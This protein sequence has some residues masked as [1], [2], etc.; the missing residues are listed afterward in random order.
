MNNRTYQLSLTNAEIEA[1]LHH[2]DSLSLRT[3]REDNN[4]KSAITKLINREPILPWVS[5]V[6]VD[7]RA[8]NRVQAIKTIREKMDVGLKEAKH[9]CDLLINHLSMIGV[10]N[11][12]LYSVYYVET[13]DPV[14]NQIFNQMKASL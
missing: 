8:G 12:T 11:S 14:A 6:V 9:A 13:D 7:I 3:I 4:L 5:G 1:I 10:I 2:L